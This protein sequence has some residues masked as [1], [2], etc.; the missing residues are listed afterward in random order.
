MTF[1]RPAK[2]ATTLVGALAALLLPAAVPAQA[3]PACPAATTAPAATPG[4]SAVAGLDG[5]QARLQDAR[6]AAF[7][8]R[9][10]LGDFVRRFPAALCATRSSAEAERLVDSWG[11]AL[12]WAAVDRA[13]GAAVAATCRLR[14]TARCTGPGSP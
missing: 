9:A 6:T 12:W 5:E 8:E 2:L 13:Q 10:G 1:A 4:A 14:T 7:T 3:Q 11:E